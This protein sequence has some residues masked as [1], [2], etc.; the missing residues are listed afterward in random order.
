MTNDL[1]QCMIEIDMKADRQHIWFLVFRE[2]RMEDGKVIRKKI[3]I[4][5]NDEPKSIEKNVTPEIPEDINMLVTGMLHKGN[6]S[7]V[8]VSFLR[9]KDWAEGILPD[10]RIEKSEGF[11]KEEIN[12]LET[13]LLEE[14]N[15]IMEQAKGV[16]PLRKMFDMH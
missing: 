6:K 4:E 5:E 16:N 11:S 12:R 15:M 14:K 2:K 8:R 10:A 13:Y 1:F 3:I 9:G 7:F